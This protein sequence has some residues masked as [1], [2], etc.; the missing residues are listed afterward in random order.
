MQLHT[1]LAF[2]G[3]CEDQFGIQWMMSNHHTQET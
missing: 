3:N 1:Y 2:N